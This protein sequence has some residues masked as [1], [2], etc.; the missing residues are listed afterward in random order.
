MIFRK[1][2]FLFLSVAL[3]SSAAFSQV[4]AKNEQTYDLYKNIEFQMPH[5]QEP[6]IP[7][8]SVSITDFG[9]INGGQILCTQAFAQAIETMSKKGGGKVIVP[10]GIWLTGPITLKS[11]IEIYT[12]GG[13]MVVFSTC[14][15]YTS[16][17]ADE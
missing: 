7:S 4:D 8:N 3:F 13:A 14:L 16:D 9:A 6:T 11:N 17:A 15:L 1:S 10:C 5:I 12:E 2:V